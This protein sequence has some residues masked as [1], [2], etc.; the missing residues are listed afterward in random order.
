MFKN[1]HVITALIVTPVLAVMGYF[2]TDYLVSEPP[3]QAKHGEQYQ[4]IQLPN[5]RYASGQ[6]GLKNGNFKLTVTSRIDNNGG[7]SLYL[8]SVFALSEAFIAVLGDP[9]E[10][11]LPTA[12]QPF[13]D[14]GKKWQLRLYAPDPQYMRLVVTT[15]GVAYYAES[16]MAFLNYETSFTKDLR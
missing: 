4:L 15:E 5:C 1:K 7:L 3:H 6:C 9:S 10:R 11:A 14:D 2:A 13:S 8:E 12:M 16:G